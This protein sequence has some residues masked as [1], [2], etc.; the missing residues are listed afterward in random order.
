[1]PKEKQLESNG[2]LKS[3][4]MLAHISRLLVF[5]CWFVFVVVVFSECHVLPSAENVSLQKAYGGFMWPCRKLYC[6]CH[7]A[8][9]VKE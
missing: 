8:R 4:G 7:T 6:T 2:L 9:T 5:F 3:G 1:M